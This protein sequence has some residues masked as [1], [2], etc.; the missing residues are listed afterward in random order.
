[1]AILDRWLHLVAGLWG[2]RDYTFVQARFCILAVYNREVAAL[3][4]FT[5]CVC[6][7]G[8]GEGGGGG[9]VVP[10]LPCRH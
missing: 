9:G 6:V 10:P 3:G 7:G 8:G 4:C 1:M 5:L 2:T